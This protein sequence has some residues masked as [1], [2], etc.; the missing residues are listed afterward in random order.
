MG[1]EAQGAHSEASPVT[2]WFGPFS[3]VFATLEV[4]VSYERSQGQQRSEGESEEVGLDAGRNALNDFLRTV[5][6]ATAQ[7][8]L[9][10]KS[11]GDRGA[12]Q[13]PTLGLAPNVLQELGRLT[14]VALSLFEADKTGASPKDAGGEAPPDKERPEDAE[15]EE[16]GEAAQALEAEGGGEVEEEP[17]EGDETAP[18]E[19][20]Q[21]EEQAAGA[22]VQRK[23]ARRTGPRPRRAPKPRA[24]AP[25]PAPAELISVKQQKRAMVLNRRMSFASS[26]FRVRRYSMVLGGGLMSVV[27]MAFSRAL[28]AFQKRHGIGVNGVFTRPTQKLVAKLLRTRY[29]L[30]NKGLLTA[31]EVKLARRRALGDIRRKKLSRPTIQKMRQLLGMPAGKGRLDATF[32]RK[33]AEFRQRFKLGLDARLDA[34]TYK[35]M[36]R[37]LSEGSW[38]RPMAGP[39]TSPFGPRWG[40]LHAGIDIGAP[41]GTPIYAAKGGKVTVASYLSGY[42]N[43]VYLAHKDGWESRYAHCSKLHVKVGD[44]VTNGQHIAA[45]GNTGHSYGAHVH[46]EIR[47][48]GSP[49]DPANFV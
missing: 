22:P 18:T 8:A 12:P 13:M 11:D 31:L 35:K 39:I 10:P 29:G 46:F 36:Q 24:A 27:T 38:R 5:D 14:P 20:T 4:S 28:A 6:L 43:V 3:A 47:K 32:L 41:N 26:A 15:A 30:D 17:E 34:R 33:V 2:R 37:E 40:R 44:T 21:A 48:G 7:Q 49:L 19:Q 25:A 45:C 9:A 42:G 16:A 23:K 1:L